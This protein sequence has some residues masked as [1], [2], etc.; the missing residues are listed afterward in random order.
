M[1]NYWVTIK[2][3]TILA[4][5]IVGIVVGQRWLPIPYTPQ[6]S[7]YTP[8]IQTITPSITDVTDVQSTRQA[9]TTFLWASDV[10][11]D[12]LP[13]SLMPDTNSEWIDM[14]GL[15]TMERMIIHQDH[16]IDSIVL[17]FEPIEPSGIFVVYHQGHAGNVALG[18]QVIVDLLEGGATVAALAM[19]LVGDNP[20]P[21]V[22]IPP[23][24]RVRLERH[25]QFA[26]L[27]ARDAPQ[28]PIRFLLTP[29]I[30]VINEA[31]VRGYSDIRM[32]GISGGGWTTTLVAALDKRIIRSVP[33]AGS[34]PLALRNPSRDW[35]DYEQHHPKLYSIATYA[36]L[37][38]LSAWEPHRSQV[39]VL[40]TDDPCCFHAD[41]RIEAYTAGVEH[42]T[43]GQWSVM[44]VESS[45]HRVEVEAVITLLE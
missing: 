43:K 39:Q 5:F 45:E 14:T 10:L 17:W 2:I 12:T 35:G 44:P 34:L 27:E 19:P 6:S 4:V 13:G 40:H 1:K 36:D 22:E 26:L 11:P 33:V 42:L 23:F 21:V 9:L 24:G 31:E 29:T 38:V 32:I 8:P 30:A 7:S 41:D 15:A 37:Y 25:D 16:R 20:R 28:H 18:R 3:L